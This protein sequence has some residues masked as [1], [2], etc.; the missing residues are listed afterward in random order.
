MKQYL[1][2]RNPIK[3]RLNA[4]KVIHTL[5]LQKGSDTQSFE[6]LAITQ[7]IPVQWVDKGQL[8]NMVG[9]ANHQ[10]VV[11]HIPDYT[12]TS[13]EKVLAST[14]NKEHSSLI[15]ADGL[16]DPHNLG[17]ILRIA[18]G[19]GVDGVIIGKHRSVSL[20]STVAKVSAGAIESVNIVEVTNLAQTLKTLKDAGYW[21]YGSDV[22]NAVVYHQAQL[23]GKVVIIVGSEG[24]GMSS[25][26]KKHC[27][28]LL[29]I[30]MHGK[31][32]SLNVA[33]ATGI[34]VY[35]VLRQRS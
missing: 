21:I 27:D 26:V 25:L 14:Q 5:Y 35:E 6:Q 24:K 29:T 30:P 18:D 28:V 2:G 32:D 33:V 8:K 3:E 31:V 16:E 17:A 20:T 13:L 11:A 12:F 10:G 9:E 34:L 22:N 1:Y 15:V 7:R 4:K 19:A 23:S